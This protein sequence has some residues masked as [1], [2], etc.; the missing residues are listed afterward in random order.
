M[1]DMLS[2]R[3][4]DGSTA[5][6]HALRRLVATI[7]FMIGA[8]AGWVSA[9]YRTEVNRVITLFSLCFAGILL[10]CAAATFAAVALFMALRESHPVAVSAGLSGLFASLAGILLAVTMRK[11]RSRR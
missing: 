5:V 2:G 10:C 3:H 8:R 6:V 11:A 4:E 9:A 7:A 1:D